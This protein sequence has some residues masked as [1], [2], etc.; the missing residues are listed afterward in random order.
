[1][2]IKGD[3]HNTNAIVK[4]ASVFATFLCRRTIFRKI[5]ESCRKVAK[6]SHFTRGAQEFDVVLNSKQ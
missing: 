5:S 4:A 3:Q 2:I 1:M 6:R